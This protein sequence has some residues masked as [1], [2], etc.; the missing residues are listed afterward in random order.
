[1]QSLTDRMAAALRSMHDSW[2]TSA[3]TLIVPTAEAR[4]MVQQVIALLAEYD[5]ERNP[6]AASGIAQAGQRVCLKAAPCDPSW[7]GTVL[8]ARGVVVAVLAEDGE[9]FLAKSDELEILLNLPATN[10]GD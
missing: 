6:P 10:T 5:A 9:M 2:D 7:R 3:E 1:M 4:T 8:Y